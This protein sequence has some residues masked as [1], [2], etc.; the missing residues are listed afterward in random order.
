MNGKR[1]VAIVELDSDESREEAAVSVSYMRSLRKERM[2]QY[3]FSQSSAITERR[4][5][6]VGLCTSSPSP[7]RMRF[8]NDCFECAEAVMA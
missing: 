6:A 1:H 8:H 3:V 2:Y 5:S 7:L 4:E